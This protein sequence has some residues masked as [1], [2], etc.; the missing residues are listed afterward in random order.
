MGFRE[1]F[2]FNPEAN[3]GKY[4]DFKLGEV[5]PENR[6]TA[7]NNF[8]SLGQEIIKPGDEAAKYF[9]QIES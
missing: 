1:M 7:R 6:L 5:S 4:P 3:K 2:G 9:E 8:A